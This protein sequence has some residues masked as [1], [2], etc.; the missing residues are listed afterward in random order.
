M[1]QFNTI[2]PNPFPPSSEKVGDAVEIEKDIVSIKEDITSLKSGLI[3][4]LTTTTTITTG[5]DGTGN[6]TP[7]ATL[8][9]GKTILGVI[10]G[11]N[12]QTYYGAHHAQNVT[13][14]PPNDY[15]IIVNDPLVDTEFTVYYTLL[16]TD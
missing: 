11:Y 6:S 16:Y 10:V 4:S 15:I 12:Y 8:H 3:K 14:Y 9:P 1:R 13:Y 7:I 2:P 5:S